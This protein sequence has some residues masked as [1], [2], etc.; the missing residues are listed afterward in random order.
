MASLDSADM[1]EYVGVA[2]RRH[3]CL[4]ASAK[5]DRTVGATGLDPPSSQDQSTY[6]RLRTLRLGLANHDNGTDTAINGFT[7]RR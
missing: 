1:S 4:R 5:P 7:R 2:D 6:L 3:L